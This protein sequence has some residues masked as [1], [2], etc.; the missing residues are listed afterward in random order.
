ELEAYKPTDRAWDRAIQIVERRGYD[1][2]R[3]LHV[4]AWDDY[5][6]APA[7]A[8]GIRTAYLPRPGGVPP[9]QVDARFDDLLHLA[10][11]FADAKHGPILYEVECKAKDVETM[12]RFVRWM[13]DEHLAQIRAFPG[14]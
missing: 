4:S 1:R 12:Q 8:R 13:Q 2:N 11:S 3:W 14:V 7:A 5:D 9:Q 6:L 10:R